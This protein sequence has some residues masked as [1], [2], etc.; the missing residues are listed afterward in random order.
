MQNGPSSKEQGLSALRQGDAASASRLLSEAIRA[1]AADAEAWSGLGVAHCQLGQVPE[2]VASLRRAVALRPDAAPLH[3]NLGRA[4]ELQGQS[5]EALG[6]FQRTLQLDS[7]HAGAWEALR[8]VGSAGPSGA[9]PALGDFALTPAAAADRPAPPAPA[10][11]PVPPSAPAVPTAFPSAPV[12]PVYSAPPSIV[13]PA[14][15]YASSAPYAGSRRP[16]GAARPANSGTSPWTVLGIIL[17][18]VLV[19]GGALVTVL[20]AIMLPIVQRARVAAQQAQRQQERA[21][22]NTPGGSSPTFKFSPRTTPPSFRTAPQYRPMPMPEMPRTRIVV[23]PT[24]QIEIPQP[25]QFTPPP[26][27]EPPQFTPP[28]MPTRP[29][30]PTLRSIPTTPPP[31]AFY[32]RTFQGEPRFRFAPPGTDPSGAPTAPTETAPAPAAGNS[33][34]TP[35]PAPGN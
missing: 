35:A 22:R 26:I 12:R 6:S 24:R 25:R 34:M 20:V 7:S 3:F 5:L 17:A 23:P 30:I 18:V 16:P 29:S 4:L 31:R 10:A 13:P 33:D 28:T 19:G 14:P 15:P 27:P 21:W 1:D 8:R 9:A 2:G 32:P 11:P